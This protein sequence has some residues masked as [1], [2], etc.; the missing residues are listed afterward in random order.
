[1]SEPQKTWTI[2]T[3]AGDAVSGHLPA[4]AHDDPTA[5]NVAPDQL[6]VELADISHR[7]YF[8]GQLLRVRD[9]ASTAADERVLWSVLVCDPYAEEP[10]P[11][12]PVVNVAIVDDYWVT[13]LDPDGLAELAAKLRAQADRLDQE[14]RPQLVASRADWAAHS[15][16]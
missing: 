2:A 1:M 10:D 13:H 7:A 3:T 4:W 5:A 8:D 14:I 12:V 9:G 11:R 6:P 15:N 16:V